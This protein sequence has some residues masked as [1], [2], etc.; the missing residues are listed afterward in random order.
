MPLEDGYGAVIGTLHDYFRDPVNDFGQYY[1]ANAMVRTPAGTYHC[2]IDV[3]SKGLPNGV[4]WRVVELGESDLHGVVA[5]PHGWHSLPSNA[6]SGALDY[7]RSPELRPEPGDFF[8]LSGTVIETLRGLPQ[9]AIYPPWKQGTSRDALADLEPL[10]ED[11]KALYVFG[12]QFAHG[13]GVHNIHQNQGDPIDSQWWAENGIWQDGA[14]LIQRQ[15]DTIVAFLNKFKTQSYVT[16]EEGH[17][18]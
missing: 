10:L 2:A 7:V 15:D 17:R 13:L 4:E 3:D 18:I 5:L 11:P 9:A 14:T 8:E 16:D 1:H 12:E 6:E